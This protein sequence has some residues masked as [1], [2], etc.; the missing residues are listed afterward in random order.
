MVKRNRVVLPIF[1]MFLFPVFASAHLAEITAS[2]DDTGI[3]VLQE[4][5]HTDEEPFK[6]LVEVTLTNTGTEAWGDFHFSISGIDPDISNVH[7]IDGS[8]YSYDPVELG[9][10][11]TYIYDP[12]GSAIARTIDSWAIDNDATY[13]TMDLYFYNNPVLPTETVKLTVMTDNTQSDVS[14]FGIC[15]YPTEVPEPATIALLGLGGLALIRRRR[16]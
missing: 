2:F 14:Y 13:A 11:P 16:A 7:F 15:L 3:G 6:G 9:S 1:L 10:D 5:G 4:F 8:M 12:S